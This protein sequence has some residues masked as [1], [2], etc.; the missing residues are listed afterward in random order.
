M[1]LILIIIIFNIIR[2]YL[3]R[4]VITCTMLM[5]PMQK[6]LSHFQLPC[7]ETQ[8]NMRNQF[9][10]ARLMITLMKMSSNSISNLCIR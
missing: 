5:I 10:V 4:N 9:H 6:T 2:M 3:L 1:A 8:I 7:S